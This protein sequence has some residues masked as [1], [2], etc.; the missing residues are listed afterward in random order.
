MTDTNVAGIATRL[1][2]L[3]ARRADL[4]TQIAD[5][6]AQLVNAVEVGG[7]VAIGDIDVYK[8][9][10]GKR[11]FKEAKA[12]AALPSAVIDAITVEKLDGTRLRKTFGEG[13]WEACCDVGDPYLK[14]VR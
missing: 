7:T 6:R 12:R 11:T 2:D 13:L 5:L 10:P 8:V 3:E 1:L 4:D 14:A 9:A